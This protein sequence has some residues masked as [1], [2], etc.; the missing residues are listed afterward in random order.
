MHIAYIIYVQIKIMDSEKRRIW[1]NKKLL[2]A[3]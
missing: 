2:N 3:Q 1:A